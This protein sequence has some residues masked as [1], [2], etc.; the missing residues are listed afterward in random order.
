MSRPRPRTLPAQPGRLPVRAALLVAGSVVSTVCYAVTIRSHLGLGPLFAVQDGLAHHA[1]IT[2]GHAVM[3]VGIALIG[4]A[5]LVRNPPGIGTV[6]L[7]FIGGATL[8]ALL[9]HVPVIHGWAI[10]G[11]AV[12]AASWIMGLGGAIVI[13][14]AIGVSALDAVM[15][16]LQRT[17][18]WSLV[19]VRLGMETAM[20]LGGWA[21]GGAVGVGTV[22]TGLLIGPSMHYWLRVLRATPAAPVSPRSPGTAPALR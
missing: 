2:I 1:G 19:A 16:G 13:R 22:I 12:V 7:P 5:V 9:P 21:L 14:A 4:L 18:G 11:I 17:L 3:I 20:L 15:L 6:L 8:D 10:R